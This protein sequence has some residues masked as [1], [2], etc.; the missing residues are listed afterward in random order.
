MH[1]GW[2]PPSTPAAPRTGCLGEGASSILRVIT[3][4]HKAGE[5]RPRSL[6][7]GRCTA[8][9]LHHHE[10][11]ACKQQEPQSD[12]PSSKVTVVPGS[13]FV[14]YPVVGACIAGSLTTDLDEAG[15][16]FERGTKLYD[17]GIYE[18][19]ARTLQQAAKE[20]E[21]LH[22]DDDIGDH[23]RKRRDDF[24]LEIWDCS[25]E[26]GPNHG[27]T[28]EN[29][30]RLVANYSELGQH[31]NAIAQCREILKNMDRAISRYVAPATISVSSCTGL[32]GSRLSF[33]RGYHQLLR[34][35]EKAL[36]NCNARIREQEKERTEVEAARQAEID[37]ERVEAEARESRARI[38]AANRE[39][40]RLLRERKEQQ[41]RERAEAE[42]LEKRRAEMQKKKKEKA[43]VSYERLKKW[44]L[45][46]EEAQ[47][48]REHL[49]EERLERERLEK[50]RLEE[51]RLEQERV[52]KKRRRKDRA[53]KAR[54]EQER[55][56]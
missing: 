33:P 24:V 43:K 46:Q 39:Q 29:R 5:L 10:T 23:D 11:G 6:A 18:A 12:I 42:V 3:R 47:R 21:P 50:Q 14:E 25:S 30:K 41:E 45:E 4:T 37:S 2:S 51:E 40:A 20:T 1:H 7:A 28:L 32:S 56:D 22:T 27:D 34:D 38:D 15:R 44:R 9:T 54:L 55:L 36:A 52:E 49:E 26:Y 16:L 35:T 8:P 31:A 53:E 13:G 48:K 17:A 19:A